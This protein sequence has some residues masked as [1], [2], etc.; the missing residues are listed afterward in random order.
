MSCNIL[1]EYINFSRKTLKKYASKIMDK[2]FD[3]DIFDRFLTVYVDARYYGNFKKIKENFDYNIG[4]VLREEYEKIKVE[5]E[6][7]YVENSFK[8]F[9]YL[10]YFD[11]VKE[12][13]SLKKIVG[14]L[15]KFRVSDLELKEDKK[16]EDEMFDMVKDDLFYKKEYIDKFISKSFSIN[17]H[18]TNNKN[19]YN[20]VLESE[21]KFPSLYNVKAINKIFNSKEIVED[22]LI[23]EYSYVAVQVLMD[24]IKG[25]FSKSYL[26]EF[27]PDVNEKKNNQKRLF[28]II[29]ND[30][31]KDKIVLKINYSDFL[32]DKES[33]YAKMRL[34]FKYAIVIDEAF[35]MND[36][37]IRFLS[38]FKYIIISA[39]STY[40]EDLEK[41]E[42]II[43]LR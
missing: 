27:V 8:T 34:G 20:S 1:E 16:F 42:N 2:K 17:Y 4:F 37:N 14:E 19:V 43:I 30:I 35:V 33:Y 9:K 23:V 3:E 11:N 22:R 31:A 28:N 24:I 38:I 18:L 7:K 25:E 39:K 15:Y 10:L 21:L 6:Q 40:Y 13:E 26:V 36:S 32:A 5:Y 12:S 29:D 41:L